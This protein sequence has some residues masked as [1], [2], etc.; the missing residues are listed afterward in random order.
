[1]IIN[2]DIRNLQFCKL[3]KFI[4]S[5]YMLHIGRFC[6]FGGIEMY[7][8]NPFGN[9]DGARANLQE[10]EYSFI[11]DF[12]FGVQINKCQDELLN[13]RVI[14]GA[15]G[16]GKTVYLRKI[17]SILKEKQ[18]EHR[19][20]IYVDEVIDQN[21]NCTE[22]VI[23]F[24][25]FYQKMTLSEKWG[26]AWK[27]AILLSLAHKFLYDPKLV[28]YLSQ[29]HKSEIEK[30]LKPISLKFKATFSVYQFMS[31]IL[32]TENTVNKMDKLINNM[33]WDYL[34]NIIKIILRTSPEIYIFLDAIDL[35]YEHAP[36]HWLN[37]QKG[38]FYALMAF[39]QDNIYGEKLHLIMSLRDNVFTSILRSEHSTK[40]SKESHVFSLDWDERN[41]KEFLKQKIAKLNDCYFLALDEQKRDIVSWLGVEEIENER[42][43]KEK[44]IDFIIR[45]TRSVPRDIINVCNELAKLHAEVENNKATII[46]DWIKS[47]V[48]KESSSIGDELLTICAKNIKVN[49]IPR[50]AAQYGL[51]EYYTSD[52]YYKES[53][54]TKLCTILGKYKDDIITPQII[55]LI[56]EEAK[57]RFNVEVHLSDILWQNGALGYLCD[58]GNTHFYAQKF[59]GDTLLPQHKDRYLL[60]SCV[61]VRLEV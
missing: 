25:D 31:S 45:H 47:V 26:K 58:H 56:N 10:I 60:R 12:P 28:P 46:G 51:T 8:Q 59:T 49:T 18:E 24:C 42:N 32:T 55:H 20:G 5:V 9:P 29:E 61:L 16:S 35:E 17:Q 13:K 54:F 15:K 21:M 50:S 37:C 1:M 57:N 43:E 7:K 33:C 4:C 27:V 48:L 30:T 38:L 6:F 52:E 19:T 44:V 36:L 41:I 53:T 23:A 2:I 40:F 22:R 3:D 11:T 34:Y 14:V 39:L